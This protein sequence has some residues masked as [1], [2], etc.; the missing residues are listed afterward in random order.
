MNPYID[1]ISSTSFLS[2]PV[3]ALRYLS[4]PRLFHFLSYIRTNPS[5]FPREKASDII[6]QM[7][8]VK[9]IDNSVQ[10]Y[11]T[12]KDEKMA[13]IMLSGHPNPICIHI[14]STIR[15][16]LWPNSHWEEL[17]ATMPGYTFIQ[18]GHTDDYKLKG[19]IDLRGQTS[20]CISA[21]LI[22]YSLAFLGL[23]S[24]LSHVTNAFNIPGVILFGPTTPVT[25][26][27]SNNINIYKGIRCSPC[28]DILGNGKCPYDRKCM[29][30][31]TV[32]EVRKALLIQLSK[33]M[34][35]Q[36]C[37]IC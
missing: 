15:N 24:S 23:D 6:A 5:L 12:E 13:R 16:K 25:W 10:L 32:E 17:I 27:H 2:N 14:S 29:N 20:F 33:R 34:T 31:I 11:L 3:N 18:L 28:V 4:D 9:L 37:T 22:K 30:L 35:D 21:A 36:E 26:G 7:V 19:A 8:N 1:R